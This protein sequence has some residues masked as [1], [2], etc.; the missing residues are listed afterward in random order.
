MSKLI[1]ANLSRLKNDTFFWFVTFGALPVTSAVLIYL[2]VLYLS[3]PDVNFLGEQKTFYFDEHYF[4]ATLA[5]PLLSALVISLFIGKDFDEKTIRNKLISGQSRTS[6]YLSNL[7]T[8]F[9]AALL[10]YAAMLF[11]GLIGIPLAEPT[12]L[13]GNVNV[14]SYVI[15]GIF[16]ALSCAS[17]ATLINMLLGNR[18]ASFIVSMLLFFGIMILLVPDANLLRIPEFLDDYHFV[19]GVLTTFPNALRNEQYVD[20]A[21]RVVR[22]CILE[23]FPSGNILMLDNGLVANPIR[24]ILLSLSFTAATSAGGI[25][26]FKRKDLK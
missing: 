2:Y 7:V 14:L 1:Y 17:A 3:R 13:S 8:G 24:E 10:I 12:L 15:I 5:L 23:F 4:I 26:L 22:E 20:G 19:D 11:G 6:V 25:Y 18:I 21:E 9:F 16:T